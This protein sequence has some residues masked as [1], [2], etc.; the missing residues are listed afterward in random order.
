MLV[1]FPSQAILFY[2]HKHLKMLVYFD[3]RR[4]F[5]KYYIILNKLDNKLIID[6][7]QNIEKRIRNSNMFSK[8][9]K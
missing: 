7:L 3:K 2:F 1:N 6:F 8:K 9:K 5:I 4:K